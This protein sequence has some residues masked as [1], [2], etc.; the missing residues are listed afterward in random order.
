M[1]PAAERNPVLRLHGSMGGS[2]A[3][4]GKAATS[5]CQADLATKACLV[6]TSASFAVHLSVQWCTALEGISCYL[7]EV[8]L[9]GF[10]APPPQ[11]N[12][13]VIHTEWKSKDSFSECCPHWDF[14]LFP[15]LPIRDILFHERIL[16]LRKDLQLF[17][18]FGIKAS[19][20]GDFFGAAS[21]ISSLEPC[22]SFC[23]E[24]KAH[25][26]GTLV[27]HHGK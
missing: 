17:L 8:H 2:R 16:Y 22:S 3:P 11:G 14:Y 18:L 23:F 12:G 15:S 26:K 5:L 7:W 13:F 4:R 19:L 24:Y 6:Q 21:C 27:F 20:R 1:F 9:H 25:S 10:G